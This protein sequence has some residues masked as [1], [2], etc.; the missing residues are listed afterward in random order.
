[1]TV[2]TIRGKLFLAHG[3]LNEETGL[4]FA[5]ASPQIFSI[6]HLYN[7]LIKRGLFKGDWPEL[8][9]VMKWHADKIF[10]NEVPEKRDQFFSRLLV[11]TGFSPKAVKQIRDLKQDPDRELAYG[12]AT[13]KTL[14]LEPL[15]MTKILRDYL[16]ERESRLRTWY[17]L[18]EEMAK[19]S[20]TSSRTHENGDL[21]ILAFIKE[22]RQSNQLRHLLPRLQFDYISLTLQCNDLCHK[23]DVAQEKVAIGAPAVDAAHWKSPTNR[24]FSLV[25]TVL[26]DLDRFHGLKKKAGKKGKDMWETGPV[27]DA[28]VEVLQGFLDG[29]ARAKK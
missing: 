11:A 24:G 16:H 19:H 18:D 10:L 28:A 13:H 26:G 20:G 23:I 9:T 8:E 22:L 1:M 27:V 14:E 5:N 21:N 17:R 29:L 15:P 2:P 7:C 3:L 25:A 4:C 6:C 12:K